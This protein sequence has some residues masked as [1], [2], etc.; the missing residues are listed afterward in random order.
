MSTGVDNV[1][2]SYRIILQESFPALSSAIAF[3][4]RRP[5]VSDSISTLWPGWISCSPLEVPGPSCGGLMSW[6]LVSVRVTTICSISSFLWCNQIFPGEPSRSSFSSLIPSRLRY[7]L[8]FV[9]AANQRFDWLRLLSCKAL[10]ARASFSNLRSSSCALILSRRSLIASFVIN[11]CMVVNRFVRSTRKGNTSN[12]T[13]VR[14]QMPLLEGK[15]NLSE[16]LPD[17]WLL[18][19]TFLPYFSYGSWVCLMLLS[20]CGRTSGETIE[21]A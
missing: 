6:R 8:H 14:Q 7:D 19:C 3:R 10:R 11:N 5:P 2:L 4:H 17:C 18:Q 12:Q 16:T 20:I 15:V 13:T 1:V 21:N 9:S